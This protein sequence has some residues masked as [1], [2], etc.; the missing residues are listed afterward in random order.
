[1]SRKL[2]EYLGV[3]NISFLATIRALEASTFSPGID[4]KLSLEIENKTNQKIHEL[5][6]DSSDSTD[7]E[8][9]AGLNHKFLSD[10]DR[11]DAAINDFEDKGNLNSKI[12]TNLKNITSDR[13][14]FAIKHSVVKKQLQN[15]PPK[16]LLKKLGYRSVD[17]LIKREPV[18]VILSAALC[19][20]SETWKSHY[21]DMYKKLTPSD[22]EER[23]IEI[24]EPRKTKSWSNLSNELL[25]LNRSTVMVSKELGGVIILPLPEK[26]RGLSTATL[27]FSLDGI[28]SIRIH[29]VFCKLQQ[30]KERVGEIICNVLL[31]K[32]DLLATVAGQEVPWHII[33]KFYNRH[34]DKFPVEIFDPHVQSEDL[35]LLNIESILSAIGPGLDFWNG[36]E[37]TAYKDFN[38]IVSFNIKDVCIN[39]LNETNFSSRSL[40]Y[41]RESLWT[42]LILR[43][44]SEESLEDS[45]VNQLD[46]K[47]IEGQDSEG[48]SLSPVF[49]F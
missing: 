43:Y 22:F 37:I 34:I 9:Y 1:M 31:G 15:L 20:E 39:A 13:N 40:E 21:Y 23:K 41:F 24:F 44:I 11:I 26:I 45:M 46:G 32:P 10:A 14:C 3:N 19:L 42:E 29:S 28:N 4:I 27:I 6:F 16:V 48:L 36:S 30:V 12:I 2:S 5:G 18:S 35:G 33:Q 8:I 7:E 49:G 38:E 47:L 25:E 17:S